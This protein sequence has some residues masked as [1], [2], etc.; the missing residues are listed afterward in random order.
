MSAWRTQGKG[1]QLR[2]P[3]SL[4]AITTFRGA[5]HDMFNESYESSEEF[6]FC[7]MYSVC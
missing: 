6:K 3:P 5:V 2:A 7:L 1:G 4:D